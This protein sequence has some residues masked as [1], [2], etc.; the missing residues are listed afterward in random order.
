MPSMLT[1]LTP[2]NQP[3]Y[4]KTTKIQLNLYQIAHYTL[5]VHLLQKGDD[6]GTSAPQVPQRISYLKLL[7]SL[8]NFIGHSWATL[9]E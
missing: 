2:S 5:V 3:F 1:H 9:T 6:G 7:L 4:R 8:I